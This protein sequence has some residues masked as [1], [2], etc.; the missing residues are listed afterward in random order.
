MTDHCSDCG[1][2]L[3]EGSKFCT[4]CGKTVEQQPIT[5]VQPEPQEPVEKPIEKKQISTPPKTKKKPRKKLIM[6]LLAIIVAAIIIVV[7]AVYLQGGAG[8]LGNADSRFVGQWEQ[9]NRNGNPRQWIFNSDSTLDINPST[10]T[11]INGTWK[12]TDN[13]LCLYNNAV[14]YTSVF[15]YDGNALTLNRIGQSESYPASINL[16]KKGLQGTSETPDIMCTTDSSTNRIIIES[17]DPN[18]KWSDIHI[19]TSGNATWQVQD[20]NQKGLARIGITATITTF[21]T[22][23]DSLL[24]LYAVGDVSVTMTFLPTNAILGNWTV[25]V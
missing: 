11:L 5:P 17:I 2:E 21:V 14:C 24:V 10:D 4:E 8:P 25:N 19:T 18:V 15:S 9:N 1:A 23:G 3:I 16:T 13:Q 22:A 6:G 20:V 12:V 7:I